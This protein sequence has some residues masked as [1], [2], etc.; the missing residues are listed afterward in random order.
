M[1]PRG[2]RVSSSPG[3]GVALRSGA[4]ALPRRRA[5]GPRPAVVQT[6][7]V[8]TGLAAGAG[9]AVAHSPS[10]Q[11][12]ALQG[13][14]YGALIAGMTLVG[15][16]ALQRGIERRLWLVWLTLALYAATTLDTLAAPGLDAVGQ[17]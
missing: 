16:V 15:C 6:A 8:G 10:F 5:A 13:V 3:G 2:T 17:I 1:R 14:L 12:P 9:V 11:H 4:F 7:L